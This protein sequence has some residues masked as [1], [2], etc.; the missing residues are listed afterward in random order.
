MS[1]ASGATPEGRPCGARSFPFSN[2]AVPKRAA[3]G[4]LGAVVD[5][6][7]AKASRFPQ[8]LKERQISTE[9]KEDF[10][11]VRDQGVYPAHYLRSPLES[12]R[13]KIGGR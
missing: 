10:E 6:V 13:V 3:T 11:C 2:Q 7:A 4:L 5:F 12:M 8:A 9:F 1:N